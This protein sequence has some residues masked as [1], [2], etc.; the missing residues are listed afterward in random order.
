L[1]L[2]HGAE[3]ARA[4]KHADLVIIVGFVDRRMQSKARKAEV[5]GRAWRRRIPERK[6]LG[7][8]GDF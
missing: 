2:G 1:S 4:E 8:V 5:Y 6:Q 3:I 7:L